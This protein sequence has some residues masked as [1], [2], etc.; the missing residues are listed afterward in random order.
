MYSL[1]Y[2]KEK[3]KQ[4]IID[5][6]HQHPFAFICGADSSGI[7]VASQIPVFIDEIDGQLILSGHIMKKTDHHKAFEENKNVLCVFT[8]AHSYVSATWYSDP[9]QAS[10]WNYMSVHA[11]GELEFLDENGL[12]EVLKRTTLHFEKGNHASTTV[13]DNLPEEY[14][15][16]LIPAIV[17]FKIKVTEMDNVFKL[18]QNRDK[19]SYGHIIEKLSSQ[20]ADGKI[21]AEE[22]KKR[23]SELF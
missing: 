7:P 16:K 20:D 14:R 18:S 11:R 2:F 1:P 23:E 17:G 3:D 5:F 21:L 4:R 15:N 9:Q 13:F 6:I 8:G 22:M 19:H 12:I 10:T